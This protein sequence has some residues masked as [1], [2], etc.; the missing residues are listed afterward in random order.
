[1]S[2]VLCIL[3]HNH[4]PD[5]RSSL[6]Q[7]SRGLMTALHPSPEPVIVLDKSPRAS[8]A[9]THRMAAARCPRTGHIAASGRGVSGVSRRARRPRHALCGPVSD[10]CRC[11]PCR[12]HRSRYHSNS[13]ATCGPLSHGRYRCGRRWTPVRRWWPAVR[14]PP[15]ACMALLE[16]TG[17]VRRIMSRRVGAVRDRTGLCEAI[18]ICALLPLAEALPRMQPPSVSR[19]QPRHCCARR[20]AAV[21]SAAISPTALA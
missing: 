7:G 8:V 1:M 5:S 21:M 15:R 10:H 2:A 4:W 6:A 19:L 13:R 3:S 14:S 20:A 16:A 17:P 18:E 11:M 9:T 12:Q